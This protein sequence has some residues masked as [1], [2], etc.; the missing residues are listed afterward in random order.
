MSPQVVKNLDYDMKTDIWS[1]GIT[2][3]EMCNGEPPFAEL[4][5]QNVMEKIGTHPPKVDEIIKKEE[6]SK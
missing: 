3:C 2:C 5:P 4:N 1:L 6:H